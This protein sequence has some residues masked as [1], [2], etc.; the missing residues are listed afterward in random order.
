MIRLVVRWLPDREV[1]LMAD[2][3]Y[4]ALELL[5]HVK[6]LPHAS[7]ITRLRLDAA[8]YDPPPKW[9]PGSGRSAP[10]QRETPSDPGGSVDSCPR[11]WYRSP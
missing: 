11:V 8:L 5:D 2:S 1:A 10:A 4:A 6:H 7:L 3:S 9:E